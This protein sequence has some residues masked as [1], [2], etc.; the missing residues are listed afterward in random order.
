MFCWQALDVPN[1]NEQERGKGPKLEAVTDIP[2]ERL[3]ELTWQLPHESSASQNSRTAFGNMCATVARGIA[4][5]TDQHKQTQMM[6]RIRDVGLYVPAVEHTKLIIATQPSP[7][8]HID[9]ASFHWAS[10]LAPPGPVSFRR[11]LAVKMYNDGAFLLLGECVARSDLSENLGEYL[12]S[13]KRATRHLIT[14]LSQF[15]Q[16]D[17]AAIW[18]GR[19]VT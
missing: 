5:E 3:C 17:Y 2:I 12:M 1:T 7:E 15:L 16:W 8:T 4:Q 14:F 9:G 11:R 6:A 13:R 10:L 18:G 19:S